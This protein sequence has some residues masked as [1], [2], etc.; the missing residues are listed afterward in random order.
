MRDYLNE[1]AATRFIFPIDGDCVN[2]RD[3]RKSECGMIL[4]ATVASK[5]GCQVTVN[6]IPA[7][8]SESG[9][10]KVEVPV[11]ERKTELVAKNLTDGTE[12]AVSVFYFPKSV[13]KYRI[14]SDD[15]ILFLA[16]ITYNKD[17]YTSI[18][19]NPYLAVYKKA[20]DLYGAKIHLNLFYEFD[21]EAAR[22]FSLPRPDF[23]LSMVTDKFKEEW[24]ANSDWLKL[25]FH[26]RREF[27]ARPYLLD[28]PEVIAKDFEDIKR[29]IVRFAGDKSFSEDAI[30][31]HYGTANAEGVAALR[32]LGHKLFMGFFELNK[33]GNPHVSYY[34]P[35]PL[36]LHVG[37]RDFFV[38]TDMGV[39]FG[40]IDKVTNTGTLQENVQYIEN[41][42]KHPQRSGFVC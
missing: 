24:E 30:T 41:L 16:D 12:A 10:Y 3:G 6:G 20:H 17:K 26:S 32:D 38:D 11:C 39:T 23:N 42:L 36:T 28:P 40:R 21:R 19:D 15:N 14:S 37:E 31:V 25:A 7:A 13:G 35:I 29:E 22:F 34:A 5:A 1:G 9:L 27:P 18:F 33:A 8:E 4:A 2:E